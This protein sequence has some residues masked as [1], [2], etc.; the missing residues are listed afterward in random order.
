MKKVSFGKF[1]GLWLLVA[2]LIVPL[3][4][5]A[6]SPKITVD[7]V[8]YDGRVVKFVLTN[9][10]DRRFLCT[11]IQAKATVKNKQGKGSVITQRS[12]VAKNVILPAGSREKKLEVDK[13][14][15]KELESEFDQPRIVDIT[16]PTYS[17]E[18]K[19]KVFQDRLKDGSLGPKMVGIP[20]GSFRIG[21]IQGGGNYNE[22]PVPEVSVA[23]F[24]MGR[25]EVT[26]AEYDKFAKATGR[27]KPDDEGWGR[28]NRPV[29]NVSWNDAT[30]YAKWLSEQTGKDYR[31]PTEAEWEYAARAR[32]ESKYWW[33]NDIN[34]G[35]ANY[36][37]KNEKWDTKKTKP[38]GS[39][40]ANAFKIYDMVGNVMEWTCSKYEE[41]Y[42]GAEQECMKGGKANQTVLRGGSFI[43]NDV[44]IAKRYR[45]WSCIS[46][47]ANIGFR[48]VRVGK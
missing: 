20:A 46:C 35:R 39:F 15:I 38:I 42:Q 44:R 25:Y 33:G 11:F 17:C 45:I 48:V 8:I 16:V 1:V 47:D 26:F 34:P 5:I 6:E 40:R 43:Q 37:K 13:E 2:V 27:K 4:G 36:R 23:R 9:H 3:A 7:P 28:G 29:I 18:H 22:K 24:A 31:L 14:F 19:L 41:S 21:D 10:E 32:T 12:I 30:D